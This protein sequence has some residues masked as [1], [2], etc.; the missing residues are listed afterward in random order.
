MNR[1]A[2]MAFSF[3]VGLAAVLLPGLGRLGWGRAQGASGP[4]RAFRP[5]TPYPLVALP[6]KAPLG[7]VYDRPPNYET[8]TPQL[9]GK[10]QY[11]FTDTETYYVRYREADVPVI[12][13]AQFRL[14]IYG[15]RAGKDLTLTLDDL[16]KYPRVEYAAVG[17]CTGL[18]R[19]LIK[20]LVPGM[21][22]TKGDVSCAVWAGAS[23]RA[24]LDD[25]GIKPGAVQVAFKS[26]GRT[27]A[28]TKAEYWRAYPVETAR[29]PEAMLAYEMNGG[30][31]PLW[32]GAPLRLV[33][34]G[35]YAPAWV[36]QLIEIEVRST[37]QPLEWSGRKITPGRLKIYSLLTEP[38]DG[39]RLTAG[40]PV[41][42][43]GVAWD[44]GTG[45]AR[46]DWS[47]DDGQTWQPATLEKSYGRFA[48]RVWRARITPQKSGLLRIL[49]RATDVKGRVQP[50]DMT[51]DVLQSGGR[52]KNN[53][54]RT[55][56]ATFEVV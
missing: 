29:L 45:I 5:G 10:R 22:W 21:P 18:G 55:F 35:T 44:D 34:P 11:P 53:S 31:M 52:N 14:R 46:V 33:I 1:R 9:I 26:A 30:S 41:D 23:L 27:V 16:K 39:T 4:L 25:V 32:N 24:V 49:T 2:F 28:L 13:P 51:P 40:Q 15:D 38:T 36:K 3:R 47:S 19:G 7:Q 54:M 56:V 50:M 6:G 8:P 20:P 48:W 42:V 43:V 17:E 37:P 12:S